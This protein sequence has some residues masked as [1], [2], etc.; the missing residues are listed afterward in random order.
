MSKIIIDTHPEFSYELAL[1]IPYANWLNEQGQLGGVVTSRGMSPFYFFADNVVEK[2]N[3]RTVDNGAAGM[4][5]IPNNWIHHNALAV[6][7]KDYQL[8]TDDEKRAINGVLDYSKWSP[9]NYREFYANEEFRFGKKMVVICNR[10]NFEHGKPPRGYFDLKCLQTLFSMLSDAGYHVVY[11]RPENTE[12][13]IDEN[14]EMMVMHRL[15]LMEEVDGYGLMSDKQLA[16]EF[17]NVSVLEDLNDRGYSYNDMQ[18]RIFANASGFIS[19][20]GG[21]GIFSSYFGVPNITYVTTSGELRPGYFDEGTYYRKLSNADIYA[22]CDPETEITKRGYR[23]YTQLY[24][25]V[26]KV[27]V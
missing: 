18:L 5:S 6:T 16:R 14:E 19:M 10:Y 12:F 24:D 7:G 13:P 25:Y 21:N 23:D 3:K 1:V 9:P 22:V 8:M 4:N 11:K 20:A 26:K 2:Y 17:V 15:S 27:F